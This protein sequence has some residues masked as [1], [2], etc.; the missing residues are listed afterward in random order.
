[1]RLA[2]TVGITTIGIGL[3]AS[4]LATPRARETKVQSDS[5]SA[6]IK[7]FAPT[8]ITADAARL[9]PGDRKALDK[10]IEAA[11]YM[12]AIFLRQVWSGNDALLLDLVKDVSPLGKARLHYFVINK[13]PWSALDHN[14]PF[15]PGVPP[16]PEAANFYPPGAS[17]S[18]TTNATSSMYGRAFVSACNDTSPLQT[19]MNTAI[20]TSKTSPNARNI[21]STKSRY[22]SG[23]I[24]CSAIIPRMV[25]P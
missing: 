15:V 16:K 3:L 21:S 22:A 13:G 8:E 2:K 1:M 24:P 17:K 6:K 4:V 25:V 10:I 11:R 9:S 14:V 7:R 18:P 19:S 12:D 5:L 20:G 23:L